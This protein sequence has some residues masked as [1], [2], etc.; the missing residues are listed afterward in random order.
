MF[1]LYTPELVLRKTGLNIVL[2]HTLWA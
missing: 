1:K 2:H